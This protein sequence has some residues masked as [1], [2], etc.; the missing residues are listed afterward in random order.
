MA[1]VQST[2]CFQPAP[3]AAATPASIGLGIS[4]FRREFVSPFAM[5]LSSILGGYADASK[6]VC[7]GPHGFEV[8]RRTNAVEDTAQM[9]HLEAIRDWADQQFISKPVRHHLPATRLKNAVSSARD[10]A[11]PQPATR[12][13][14][15]LQPETFGVRKTPRGCLAEWNICHDVPM[16]PQSQIMAIAIWGVPGAK[17]GAARGGTNCIPFF[18]VDSLYHAGGQL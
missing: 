1:V 16:P 10:S 12:P 2:T 3:A 11:I 15:D 18:H 14:N 6:I 7:S 13:F 5:G 9:V 8:G 4:V 17:V